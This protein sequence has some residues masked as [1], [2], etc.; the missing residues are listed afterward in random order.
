MYCDVAV[1][2]VLCGYVYVCD[3]TCTTDLNQ[4]GGWQG[5]GGRHML[6]LHGERVFI[7]CQFNNPF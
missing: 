2:V 5:G 7:F 4:I 6:Q 1:D 3:A